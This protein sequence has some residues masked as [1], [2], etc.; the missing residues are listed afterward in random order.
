MFV[1]H[2]MYIK[3]TQTCPGHDSTQNRKIKNEELCITYC[4]YCV[5]KMKMIS[6]TL[7]D[8]V[9]VVQ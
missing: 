5:N 2:Y 7:M 6:S 3:L 4:I 9:T 8:L 1:Y